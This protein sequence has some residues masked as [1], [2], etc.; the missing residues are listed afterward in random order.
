MKVLSLTSPGRFPTV[1]HDPGHWWSTLAASGTHRL[2]RFSANAEWWR[3][4]CSPGIAHIVGGSLARRAVRRIRGT[5]LNASAM[6]AGRAL[7]QLCCS[8]TYES[9]SR[10]IETVSASAEHVAVLNRIQKG[11]WFSLESGVRVVGLD[12]DES[13]VLVDYARRRTALSD[14]IESSLEACPREID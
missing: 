3:V 14:L 4:L 13:R 2:C 5:D 10:Y 9:A 8:D 1:V 7:E 6:R 11:L 12:Y